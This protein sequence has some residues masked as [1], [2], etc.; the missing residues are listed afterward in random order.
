M[1]DMIMWSPGTSLEEVEKQVILKAFRHFRGNKTATANALGIAIRTLDNKL[2]KYQKDGED[3][4]RRIHEERT[5]REEFL[6]RQRG[7]GRDANGA[8]IMETQERVRVQ[9][10]APISPQQS[11][12]LSEREKI[13]SMS[14]P[15][16]AAGYSRKSR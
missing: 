3:H 7:I 12:S 5:K 14:S 15:Q 16:V 10:T 8:P 13:Q 6:I 1:S 4:E 9:P 2:E 11:M